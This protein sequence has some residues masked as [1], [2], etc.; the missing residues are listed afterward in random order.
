MAKILLIDDSESMLAHVAAMLRAAAHEVVAISR[1]K[2]V[3][4][5]L[6][7]LS[8]DLILTDL[9]MPPPDGFELIAV[10]RTLVPRVPL[11]VMSTNP[12][13][14]DVFRAARAL[15]AV[16]ALQKP[17]SA[18]HLYHVIDSALTSASQ[19]RS[20]QSLPR[21]DIPLRKMSNS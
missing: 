19:A 16:A 20:P 1:G 17:F 13:A 5:V 8:V 21:V 7:E 11:I 10:A 15:G 12:L 9:Y 6:H 14:I 4:G 18:E 3:V 2:D